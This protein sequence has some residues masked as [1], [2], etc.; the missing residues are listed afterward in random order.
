MHDWPSIIKLSRCHPTTS[1]ILGLFRTDSEEP[2]SLL[3]FAWS[4]HHGDHADYAVAASTRKTDLRIPFGY[5]LLWDLICW[6]KRNG[7]TWFDLAGVTSDRV[8]ENELTAGI[9]KFKR[10]FSER[11][12]EVGDEWRLEPYPAR[13]WLAHVISNAANW[14]RTAFRYH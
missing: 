14:V 1:R 12:V 2:G 3:A 5:A 7:A 8:A 10:Y 13:A 11:V 6:A 9:S 4:R